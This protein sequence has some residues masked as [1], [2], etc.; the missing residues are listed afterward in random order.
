MCVTLPGRVV[1]IGDRSETSIPARIDVGN[2]E[3]PADLAMVP[4]AEVG[5]YVI[6]H[7]GFAIKLVD[8]RTAQ[9]VRGQLGIAD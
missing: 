7:S 3:A 2:R 1:W 8:I 9:D 6:A 4:E 5:D